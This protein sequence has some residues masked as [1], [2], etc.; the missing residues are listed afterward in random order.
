MSNQGQ[1]DMINLVQP[2]AQ[3][4]VRP[5]NFGLPSLNVTGNLTSRRQSPRAV[6]GGGGDTSIS[7]IPIYN[8]A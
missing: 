1:V 2:M 6:L 8:E 3:G 7:T 4:I 5:Q